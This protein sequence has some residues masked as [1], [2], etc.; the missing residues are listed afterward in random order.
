MTSVYILKV[1]FLYDKR[2]WRRIAIRGDQTL[3][4]L[5]EAIYRAFDRE[6]EHLYSF[7]FPPL[8]KKITRWPRDAREYTDPYAAE[9]DLPDE[10][11][12]A[13]EAEFPF[14]RL[15]YN[16]ALAKMDMLGLEPKQKFAYLFDFGDEWWHEIEVE[17]TDGTPERGRYPRIL[18]KR[19]ESPPQ[20]PDYEDEDEE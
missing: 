18:E 12:A 7:F 1:K 3:D 2:T 5:H 6:E 11:S 16:A 17:K 20:Y 14:I 8:G 9:Y 19:G 10:D 4:T 15:S 13:E